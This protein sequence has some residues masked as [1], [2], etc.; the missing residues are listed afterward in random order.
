MAGISTNRTNITL[1][2]DVSSEIM[3]KT[4]EQSAVMTLETRSRYPIRL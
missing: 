1:P 3:Q 4:Q 2:A